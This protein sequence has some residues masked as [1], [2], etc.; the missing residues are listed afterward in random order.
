MA[1]K[2]ITVTS[3]PITDEKAIDHLRNHNDPDVQQSLM[4]EKLIA[5]IGFCEGYTGRSI[6]KMTLEL[7][8]DQFPARE[9]KL[10]GCPV[11]SIES[12]KYIDSD[13]DEQTLTSNQY[14]LDD[15]GDQHWL[16]PAFDVEWPSTRCQANAVKVRYVAGYNDDSTDHTFQMLQAAV[17]LALSDLYDNRTAQTEKQLT[18]NRTVINLLN[19]CRISYGV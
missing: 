15:Y 8:L 3:N 5:A 4:S 13:G 1:V 10:P 11:Q 17:L 9:I 12:V 6:R 18:E 2:I 14:L 19:N 7:A 16:L